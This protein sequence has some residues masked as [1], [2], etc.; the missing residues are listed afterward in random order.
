[1][2]TS[3]EIRLIL[4]LLSERTVIGPTK[5]FPYRVSE[6]AGGY[7]DDP[8]IGALQAKLSIMLEVAARREQ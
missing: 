5:K 1:M 8:T 4:A 2:L 6:R 3:N 7:S